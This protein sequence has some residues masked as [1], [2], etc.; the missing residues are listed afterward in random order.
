M[1]VPNSVQSIRSAKSMDDNQFID[2]KLLQ[3]KV[4]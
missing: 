1:F 3:N 4:A 2:A